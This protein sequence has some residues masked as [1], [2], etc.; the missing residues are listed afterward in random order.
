MSQDK[1]SQ[2]ELDQFYMQYALQLADKAEQQGEIPVG[3]V[4]VRDRQI[5][6][7]GWNQSIQLNDPSAHAEMQA[8]RQAGA[9]I[10]NYRMLD[11]TLYVTLEPCPMCAGLL[12][13][14]RVN[15]VV[16]GANDLKTGA[17]GSLFNLAQDERLNHQLEVVS[18][19]LEEP[20]ASKLSNFFRR[21]RAEKKALKKALKEAQQH[22]LQNDD[23][24]G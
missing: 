21:R 15:R 13:H 2:A 4:I 22:A 19:V 14:S 10:A 12:V 16:F 7:E 17:C 24:D 5:I 3:A 6:G 9:N 18:G 8:V 20:C 1:Q 23:N 11:T